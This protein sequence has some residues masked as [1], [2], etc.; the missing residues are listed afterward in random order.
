MSATQT[1]HV[2]KHIKI[3]LAVFA[4][5]V[6]GTIATVTAASVHLG[7]VVGIVVATCIAAFKSSLVAGFFMHLI[8]ERRTVYWIL[9]LTAA[10]FLA[11]IGLFM[12][13]QRDQQGVER[14][15]FGVPA[16]HV[17]SHPEAAHVP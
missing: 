6:A 2:Q 4:A 15:I 11:M 17:Q 16:R 12:V 3:Y 8:G 13:S 9:A 14:N 5:L 10:F 1:E 7:L